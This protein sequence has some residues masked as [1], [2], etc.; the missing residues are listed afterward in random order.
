MTWRNNLPIMQA[1]V[2]G[3]KREIHEPTAD[4]RRWAF[5]ASRVAKATHICWEKVQPKRRW[6]CVSSLEEHI[7][8][9]WGTVMPH[10]RSLSLV[11]NLLWIANQWT[12]ERRDTSSLNQTIEGQCT[13]GDWIPS[14]SQSTLWRSR[15][16]RSMMVSAISRCKDPSLKPAVM[17][18]LDRSISFCFG[19]TSSQQIQF[20]IFL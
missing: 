5:E 1:W 14:C 3:C 12:K 9:L 7:I 4:K 6:S 8:Q 16:K 11:G 15:L 19:R 13:V 17:W 20:C 10:H 2:G 18:L